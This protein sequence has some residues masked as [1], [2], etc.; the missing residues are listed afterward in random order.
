MKIANGRI[1]CDNDDLV[2]SD[3]P[4]VLSVIEKYY[5]I[6]YD[7]KGAIGQNIAAFYFQLNG[8]QLTIGWD[9][10]SGLFIMANEPSGDFMLE[11]IF[12]ILKE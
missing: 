7:N 2:S 9:N 5:E 4:E 8:I 1:S 10:W 12:E 11:K 6:R 3:I